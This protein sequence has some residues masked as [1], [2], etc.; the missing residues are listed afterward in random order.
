MRV[1]SPLCNSQS[2]QINLQSISRH[3][4]YV[5]NEQGFW[6][7]DR[8]VYFVCLYYE[9]TLMKVTHHFADL[10]LKLNLTCELRASEEL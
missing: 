4:Y 3:E 7:R 8:R 5:L 6:V 1:S 10:V 2:L 9:R